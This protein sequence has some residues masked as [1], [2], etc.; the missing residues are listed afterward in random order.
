MEETSGRWFPVHSVHLS[1][2][3]ARG[4]GFWKSHSIGHWCKAVARTL[5]RGD[6]SS[7]VFLSFEVPPT[8]QLQVNLVVLI[9]IDDSPSFTRP[10]IIVQLWRGERSDRLPHPG[11]NPRQ[12]YA[13]MVQNDDWTL[14]ETPIRI[15]LSDIFGAQIP[16]AYG[17]HSHVDLETRSLRESIIS[18]CRL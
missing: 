17:N 14:N 7:S 3:C 2:P 8:H 10:R 4:R 11:S 16:A 12:I 5:D 18:S 6:I 15:L 9:S 13:R 1:K